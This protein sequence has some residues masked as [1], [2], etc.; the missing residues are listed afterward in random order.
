M[1]TMNKNIVLKSSKPDDSLIKKYFSDMEI[2]Y[3][4]LLVRTNILLGHP[5]SECAIY[6]SEEMNEEVLTECLNINIKNIP[7]LEKAIKKRRVEYICARYCAGKAISKII[8]G[9][10]EVITN[11]LDRSPKW[12]PGIIGSITH[13]KNFA[14]VAV[15]STNAIQG[16]G[17][18][19]EKIISLDTISNIRKMIA[20]GKEIQLASSF[21]DERIFYTIVFSAKE[22]IFKCIYPLVNKMFWYHDVSI[23]NINQDLKTFSGVLNT[24]LSDK[25]HGGMQ[26][27]G[28]YSIDS[29][30]VH[31]G[32]VLS[33]FK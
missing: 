14:A 12:P 9:Y 10:N 22:S 26:I 21:A 8:P 33:N 30:Y 17:I 2:L 32:V 31:T 4:D 3:D 11:K 23:I 7:S 19:A 28:V 6:F 20:N 5:I 1:Y 16:I 24:D 29:E 25:F 27:S 18:D 15:G 13:T